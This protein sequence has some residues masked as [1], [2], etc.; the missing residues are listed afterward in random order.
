MTKQMVFA[1]TVA[2]DYPLKIMASLESM[3]HGKL[4]TANLF[5]EGGQIG[6]KIW[7]LPAL[8]AI[9]TRVIYMGKIIKK[10]TN[11]PQ[12]GGDGMKGWVLN[13]ALSGHPSVKDASLNLEK[14][15][16]RAYLPTL[17]KRKYL[18]RSY[19]FTKDISTM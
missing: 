7:F 9:E 16:I 1:D 10:S 8:V 12:Q 18:P 15:R 5:L 11:M 2:R 14:S 13:Q 6:S 19:Q 17:S 4:I 3:G